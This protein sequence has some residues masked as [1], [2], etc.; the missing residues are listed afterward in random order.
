MEYRE[1]FFKIM[2]F[3]SYVKL[4]KLKVILVRSHAAGLKYNKLLYNTLT[5]VPQLT[6]LKSPMH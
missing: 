2:T 3:V 6:Q 5:D 4:T 1:L